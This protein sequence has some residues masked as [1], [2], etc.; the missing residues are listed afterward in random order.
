MI[1]KKFENNSHLK[2]FLSHNRI[3]LTKPVSYCITRMYHNEY[4]GVLYIQINMLR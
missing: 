4:K 2:I 1:K 3:F